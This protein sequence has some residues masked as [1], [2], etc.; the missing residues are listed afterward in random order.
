MKLP[1]EMKQEQIY[2]E[3]KL[4]QNIYNIIAYEH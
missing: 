2:P 4:D 3:Q 1:Q